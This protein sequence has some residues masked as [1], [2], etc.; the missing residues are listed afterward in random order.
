VSPQ[1][2]PAGRLEVVEKLL[3]APEVC[4]AERSGTPACATPLPA[5]RLR[6]AASVQVVRDLLT[7]DPRGQTSGAVTAR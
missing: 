7:H 2:P 4:S 1:G 3:T 6:K 5:S